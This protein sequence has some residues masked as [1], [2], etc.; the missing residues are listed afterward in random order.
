MTRVVPL[1][2]GKGADVTDPRSYRT[3]SLVAT[4]SKVAEKAVQ[5]QVLE[6]MN[7][8]NMLNH[9]HHA[10][11]PGYNTTTT[12]LQ[13]SDAI[14]T[15]TD[16]SLMTTLVAVDESAAFDCVAHSILIRKLKKYG[17]GPK[18]TE[19]FDNYLSGRR[20]YISIGDKSS[21]TVNLERG[22]PQGSVLG[23]LLYTL[24]VNE[25]PEAANREDCQDDTHKDD[26]TLFPSNCNTCG[27][28]PCYADDATLAI[29]SKDKQEAQTMMT[30]TMERVRRFLNSNELTVNKAK[31]HIVQCMIIQ[32][33]AR[34]G[35]ENPT[36]ETVDSEG[37]DNTIRA[38]EHM[39]LLGVNYSQNLTWD[40]HLEKGEKALLPGIRKT[41]GGLK[42][43][44]KQIPTASRVILANG[45]ILS[46]VQ[47][48]MALWG[49][50]KNN[51][52]RRI[53]ATLN[54][55]ARW[56]TN[57]SRHAGTLELMEKCKWNTVKEMTE[58]TAILAIWRTIWW[59][60]P[61]QVEEQLT[62][63]EDLKVD[64]RRPR[65]LTC[66]KNFNWRA[67]KLWNKLPQSL[68]EIQ[69]ITIFKKNLKR[70]IL[71]R[72]DSGPGPGSTPP[73]PPPPPLP[74]QPPPPRTPPGP[75]ELPQHT[76]NSPGT[77]HR[78]Q[79][80]PTGPP[81]PPPTSTNSTPPPPPPPGGGHCPWIVSNLGTWTGPADPGTAPHHQT[82]T[83]KN[84]TPAPS[85]GDPTPG[86]G[87]YPWIVSNLGTVTG[88]ANPG[89]APHRPHTS[90]GSPGMRYGQIK[91]PLHVDRTPMTPGSSPVS[92]RT[93]T[94]ISPVSIRTQTMTQNTPR[95]TPGTDGTPSTPV[96]P[97]TGRTPG[98][99]T[100]SRTG[101]RSRR[102]TPGPG[103]IWKKL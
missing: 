73:L 61:R 13:L 8:Y 18:T 38:Q 76:T 45:L 89:G 12:L 100:A 75:P 79:T 14:M 23:P 52:I 85:P 102:R 91:P 97:G 80:K 71:E 43:I 81:G 50:T 84:Q 51:N 55:V 82:T 58:M 86:G 5:W 56:A 101:Q 24:Y 2:K 6:H 29:P 95:R 33:R 94:M 99:G 26:S 65:L 20:Q 62:L 70:V 78:L 42:F 35:G 48:A 40:N 15:A 69:E 7:K 54:R 67:A 44:S 34:I 9:N 30:D 1:H 96:T 37:K 17:F 3:I 77:P 25:L 39:R 92:I 4:I 47:Y 16:R 63:T 53:Q 27:Q 21:P 87:A 36:I 46:R 57:S 83:N 22:V 60:I 103:M 72:R 88:P 10:Y 93:Q 41:L 64:T 11:R 74:P 49:G 31:T 66:R 32:K 28:I 90:P 68:R 59:K 98:S 19:W